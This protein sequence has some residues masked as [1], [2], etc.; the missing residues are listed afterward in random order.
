MRMD[1]IQT[2]PAAPAPCTALDEIIWAIVCPKPE[3]RVPRENRTYETCRH[4]FLPKMS[5]N[6]PYSGCAQHWARTND[7]RSHD[8][9]SRSLNSDEILPY[10]ARTSVVAAC[11]MKTPMSNTERVAHT[12]GRTGS[13]EV[14]GF[15]MSLDAELEL[16]P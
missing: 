13:S 8:P 11:D 6:F 16:S 4:T 14:V 3:P 1:T 7:E 15:S 5:L 9:D 2:M 12:F 10:V